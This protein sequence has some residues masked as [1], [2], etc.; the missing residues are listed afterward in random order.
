MAVVWLYVTTVHCFCVKQICKLSD[1][2]KVAN[3]GFDGP[4]LAYQLLHPEGS[5]LLH[6]LS[7]NS[8]SARWDGRHKLHGG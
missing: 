8:V 2:T 4:M 1:F 3:A 5:L 6:Q 7:E